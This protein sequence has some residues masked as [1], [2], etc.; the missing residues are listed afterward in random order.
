VARAMRAGGAAL[1]KT[2]ER[3]AAGMRG[4]NAADLLFAA[5]VQLV[6]SGP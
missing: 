3:S 4:A 6:G 2:G 5:V 1:S